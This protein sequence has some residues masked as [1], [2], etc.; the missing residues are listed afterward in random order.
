MKMQDKIHAP[1]H[2]AFRQ[3]TAASPQAAQK[4]P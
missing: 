3:M 2:N 4:V 1:Q